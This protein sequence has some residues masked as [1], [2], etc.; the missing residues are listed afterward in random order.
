MRPLTA[1][2][3]EPSSTPSLKRAAWTTSRATMYHCMA[4]L[5]LA[6]T[7]RLHGQHEHGTVGWKPSTVQNLEA[8]DSGLFW[9]FY[10][11]WTFLDHSGLDG[12]FCLESAHCAPPWHGQHEHGLVFLW[13]ATH[14]FFLRE[15]HWGCP[16]RSSL[17]KAGS[18]LG[19]YSGQGCLPLS[20][21]HLLSMWSWCG[22]LT[23][24]LLPNHANLSLCSILP[25]FCVSSISPQ[26][27]V[28]PEH[29]N[30]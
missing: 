8:L 18:I 25:P 4:F 28:T 1:A 13:F 20:L 16:C 10:T 21:S 11:F 27:G 3:A 17:V 9:T 22:E 7:A 24:R 5:V 19:R 15:S 30:I 14:C 29:T 12:L 2:A 26:S 23:W 6:T